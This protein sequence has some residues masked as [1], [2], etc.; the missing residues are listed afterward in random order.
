MNPENLQGLNKKVK[1]NLFPVKDQDQIEKIQEIRK[2]LEL[3]MLA[4]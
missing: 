4:I 3:F 1:K 2:I